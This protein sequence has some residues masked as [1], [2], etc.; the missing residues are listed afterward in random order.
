MECFYD[1][2]INDDVFKTTGSSV[3]TGFEANTAYLAYAAF[4]IG[5]TYRQTG[6][7]GT[8]LYLSNFRMYDITN[9]FQQCQYTKQG[10]LDTTE[11]I[12]LSSNLFTNAQIQKNGNIITSNLYE[13]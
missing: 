12:E 8:D 9:G 10:I 1:F 2:T 5:F 4:K 6:E 3:H 11:V 7:L 13:I